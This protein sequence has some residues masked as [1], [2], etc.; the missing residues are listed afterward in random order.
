MRKQYCKYVTS[1]FIPLHLN[2]VT[3]TV[4]PLDIIF[5]IAA[6]ATTHVSG[7]FQKADVIASS[8]QCSSRNSGT[9][10]HPAQRMQH[11]QPLMG[12]AERLSPEADTAR[13]CDETRC[14]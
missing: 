13:T 9:L 1:N 2:I 8:K 14:H 11:L 6:S 3:P 10:L 5:L 7:I 4:I 12:F